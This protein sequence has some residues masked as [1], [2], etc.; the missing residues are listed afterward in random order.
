MSYRLKDI[1][2]EITPPLEKVWKLTLTRNPDPLALRSN[3]RRGISGGYICAP[4]SQISYRSAYALCPVC[5]I[6]SGGTGTRRLPGSG[7]VLHY[8]ELPGPG[9]VLRQNVAGSE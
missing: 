9:R 4:K 6:C 8:P 5:I 3:L 2:P 7:R 1:S